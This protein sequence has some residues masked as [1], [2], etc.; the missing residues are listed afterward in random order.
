MGLGIAP[1]TTPTSCPAD[2]A[3]RR[4]RA[5]SSEALDPSCGRTSRQS[6][7]AHERRGDEIFQ[8][9]NIRR[10]ITVLLIAHEPDIAEYATRVV[11]PGQ[12]IVSDK[13][14]NTVG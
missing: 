4:H 14:S 2:A 9:L 6:R 10:G 13:P 1:A 3:A 12:V 8:R 11:V 7:Y 5:R